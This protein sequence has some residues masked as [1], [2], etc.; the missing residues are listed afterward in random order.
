MKNMSKII[1][2]LCLL[3][4]LLT[5]CSSGTTTATS[6]GGAAVTESAVYYAD[7][8]QV[9]ALRPDNGNTV[10]KYPEKGSPTRLFLAAPVVVDDQILLADYGNL[11]TSLDRRDGVSENWQFSDAQGKYI[12]SPLVIGET[13][14]APNADGNLYAL[15]INGKKLWSFAA[16]HS[17]W[18]QPLSDGEIVYAPCTDHFLYAVDLQNGTLKWKTDL[19]ASLVARAT[20]A[21]GII[22]LGNLDGDFFAVDS[23][24][25]DIVWTQSIAGG[26]WAA[27]NLVDDKLYFGDQSGMI[28]ILNIKNGSLV[29]NIDTE[30][31]ILGTG[32]VLEDGIVFGKEN[33]DL[34]LIGLDGSEQWTHTVK[35]A[36]YSNIAS[37]DSMFA[38]IANK[39]E[40]PLVAFDMTGKQLWAFT[41]STK[42]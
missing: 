6:W 22:Y 36:L 16:G 27:P 17:F 33:G 8:L 10:W 5:A 30:S 34:V 42:K 21:D 11:L 39:G 29:K 13:I 25:G 9:Y 24:N 38:V 2:T 28:N 7:G 20:M 40:Y 23:D 12:D 37:D 18:A 26:I 1:V 35:G 4:L 41:T 19:K 15:N 32:V 14:V 3:V 31:S